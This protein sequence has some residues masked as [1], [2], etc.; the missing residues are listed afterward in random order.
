MT[1]L[2]IRVLSNGA[3]FVQYQE[4]GKAFDA[5]FRNWEE[6]LEWLPLKI[7]HNVAP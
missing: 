5:G 1:N 6:F 4:N 3:I 2:N 7:Y